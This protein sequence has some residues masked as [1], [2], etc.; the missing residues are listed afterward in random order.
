MAARCAFCIKWSCI[1]PKHAETLATTP[2]IAGNA[3]AIGGTPVGL[4]DAGGG[5]PAD[6]GAPAVGGAPADGGTLRVKVSATLQSMLAQ[7]HISEE[8]VEKAGLQCV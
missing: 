3:S 6:G 8:D 5:A 2:V 4:A 1:C 7:Q